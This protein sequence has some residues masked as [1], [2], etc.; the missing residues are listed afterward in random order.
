MILEQTYQF[1]KFNGIEL[2][3]VWQYRYLGIELDWLLTMNNHISYV[4]NKVRPMLYTLGKFRCLI[5]NSTAITIYKSLMLPI[6]ELGLFL[7]TN[8]QQI[9]KLQR[10]QNKALRLCYRTD[11]F[12]PSFP[13]HTSARLLSLD[14][15]QRCALLNIVN[16]KLQKV[17]NTFAFDCRKDNRVRNSTGKLLVPFP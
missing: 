15:R 7:I 16:L 11:K 3:H 5:D 12:N 2:G 13:L 1:L 14:L 9:T 6:I 4:T 10:I 17:D 8:K